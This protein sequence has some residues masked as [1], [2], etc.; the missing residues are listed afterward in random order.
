V[1]KGDYKMGL[2]A[3][4][5]RLLSLSMRQD[6][7]ELRGQKINNRRLALSSKMDAIATAYSKGMSNT[8]L[9]MRQS[10]GSDQMTTF[11]ASLLAANGMGLVYGDSK[12]LV[13]QDLTGD[14]KTNPNYG[15]YISGGSSPNFTYFTDEVIEAKIVQGSL[16]IA[17]LDPNTGKAVNVIDWRSDTTSTV[18]QEL[19][20]S[21]D[22]V[23]AAKYE[24][25]ST[26]VQTA[27]KRLEMEL[28][29]LDTQH[30]AIETEVDAVK[31]VI[32]KNIQGSF[33]TFG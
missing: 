22:K 7:N 33:K 15:K 11:K 19:D 9:M 26:K 4:Q 24:A 20:E 17:A 25:D 8:R 5:A 18:S 28:K 1:N 16:S 32:D 2:A 23:V 31:K 30:K 12:D 10:S 21:D 14:A 29:D 3:S 13:K 6:D 27:D